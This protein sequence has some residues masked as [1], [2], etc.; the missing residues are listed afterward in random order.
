MNSSQNPL[1]QLK[2]IQLP[3]PISWWPLSFSSWVLIFSISA[4]LFATLWFVFDR[5][6]RN[7]YRR[8]A[9]AKLI[10]IG[11]NHQLSSQQKI[12]Q[13][14]A[15]LKQ[16]AITLYGRQTVTVLNEQAWLDFLKS[17]AQFIAQP[18]ELSQLLNQAYQPENRLNPVDLAR[19]LNAWQEYAQLWIKGHHL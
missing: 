2:D 7:A 9:Q 13:I 11:N 6:K 1:D 18:S 3:D 14:N 19:A 12:L 15:L 10:T 8:E 4:L 17:T 5:H 16:V